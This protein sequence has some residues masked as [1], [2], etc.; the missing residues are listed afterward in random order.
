MLQK[1]VDT[2]IVLTGTP[3]NSITYDEGTSTISDVTLNATINLGTGVI[4]SGA[5]VVLK[6]DGSEKSSQPYVNG[7][8]VY[9]Y[10]DTGINL[11]E[12]A[13][14]TVEVNYEIGGDPKVAKDTLKYTFVLPMFYGTSLTSTVT[15]PEALTKITSLS[16]KQTPLYSVTN[17]YLVFAIPA[18]KTIKSLKDENGFENIYSWNFVTQNVNLGNKTKSYKVY[19]TNTPVNCTNF[20][21][22]IE[23]Q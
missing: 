13:T 19:V 21:Y 9:T 20:G 5:K 6:K 3:D 8:L 22:T 4:P 14:Y 23:L 18:T 16:N 7:T 17:G 1:D 12:S 10:T 15:N 11:T 2:K